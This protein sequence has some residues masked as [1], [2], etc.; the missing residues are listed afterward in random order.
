L[1]G[2]PAERQQYSWSSP[3]IPMI[4]PQNGLTVMSDV[5]WK[6]ISPTSTKAG[7]PYW[8]HD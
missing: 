5:M 1:A 3:E 8:S 7:E 2:Q 6:V 4:D